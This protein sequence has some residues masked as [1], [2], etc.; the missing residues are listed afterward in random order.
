M[1]GLRAAAPVAGTSSALHQSLSPLVQLLPTG[2]R[3]VQPFQK[4]RAWH[5]NGKHVSNFRRS[6]DEKVVFPVIPSQKIPPTAAPGGGQAHVLDEDDDRDEGVHEPGPGSTRPPLDHEEL[7]RVSSPSAAAIPTPPSAPRRPLRGD[8]NQAAA[9]GSF[10]SRAF[11]ASGSAI[12]NSV[13]VTPIIDVESAAMTDPPASPEQLMSKLWHEYAE[14]LNPSHRP[15]DKDKYHR[16]M[17]HKYNELKQFREQ[18]AQL[19]RELAEARQE[20]DEARELVSRQAAANQRRRE[21]EG[22]ESESGK[23]QPSAAADNDSPV[24]LRQTQQQPSKG[25]TMDPEE[26]SYREKSFRLERALGEMKESMNQLQAR[27]VGQQQQDRLLIES[28]EAKLKLEQEA[29]ELVVLQLRETKTAFKATS[30]ELVEVQTELE[31]ERIHKQIVLEQVHAETQKLITD[32]RRSELQSRVQSV[33]RTLGKEALRHKLEAL[34][35]RVLTAE[36]HMRI[37]QLEAERLTRELGAQRQQMEA[38]LSSSALKYHTLAD[39]GGIPGILARST[40][41]F[42][43]TRQVNGQYLLVQILFEDNR[44]PQRNEAD[45]VD[46]DDL[47]IHYIV[48][49]AWTAQDDHLTLHMRDIKRLVPDYE[50]YTAT[51]AS[52][53]LERFQ[54]LAE[55]LFLQLHV[56]YKN[57]HIILA[58]IPAPSNTSEQGQ[59]RE[60]T[61]YR[62]TRYIQQADAEVAE[63]L[64]VDVVINEVYAPATSELWWLEIHAAVL[65]CPE[66]DENAEA[67]VKVDNHMLTALCPHLG[68]YRPGESIHNQ[69]PGTSETQ[70]LGIHE[71]LLEPLLE[72][73]QLSVCSSGGHEVIA[74][75]VNYKPLALTSFDGSAS[76]DQVSNETTDSE[77]HASETALD[78]SVSRRLS[79]LDHR[80][81]ASIDSVFYSVRIQE[82]WDGELMLEI[83][84]AD[85]ESLHHFHRTL[86]ETELVRIARHLFDTKAVQEDHAD[87]IKYGLDSQLYDP[88]CRFIK[89]NSKPIPPVEG[90]ATTA[91]RRY[92]IC[93]DWQEG[94]EA[95]PCVTESVPDQEPIASSSGILLRDVRL[96][97]PAAQQRSKWTDVQVLITGEPP[98]AIV[99]RVFLRMRDGTGCASATRRRCGLQWRAG[100]RVY[101]LLRICENI[102]DA[103]ALHVFPLSDMDHGDPEQSSELLVVVP[104][105]IPVAQVLDAL[106]IVAL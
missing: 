71:E 42:N 65:E 26:L 13:P 55:L 79:G 91:A 60:L 85:P 100:K 43:G 41:L 3:D 38:V 95:V 76:M 31:R 101:S 9:S 15:I 24:V 84:M 17:Q 48:Y 25:L 98:M 86:S 83:E 58:E 89:K 104:N 20:R 46:Q 88:I 21:I 92:G 44:L 19:E 77:H 8:S 52:R 2:Y 69:A 72:K 81:I 37:A 74:L 99:E 64:L 94:R 106:G 90:G 32:H 6:K 68:S 61:I 23:Q 30:D 59:K 82:I 54:E 62:G 27:F 34:H 49:E 39:D 10:R 36:H 102:M 4:G 11:S 7:A 5:T 105:T 47:L 29:R 45:G 22:E 103:T 96:D 87:R 12:S 66:L 28:L 1:H 51:Y 50:K 35:T 93:I 18:I 73:L 57:G 78:M 33:V 53:K 97:L 56:G 63:L 80:C 67:S 14:R 16:K 75:V 40:P 70:L